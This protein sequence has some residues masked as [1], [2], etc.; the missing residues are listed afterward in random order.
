[1]N[2][3]RRHPRVR[4]LLTELRLWRDLRR[5]VTGSTV[6]APGAVPLPAV[7]GLWFLPGALTAATVIEIIAIELLIPWMSARIIVTVISVYSLALLWAILGQRKIYPHYVLAGDLVIRHGRQPVM[8][9]SSELILRATVA[10]TYRSERATVRD[11]VLVLGNGSGTSL[12]IVLAE[13][14]PV[15]DPDRWP[16]QKARIVRATEILLWVD[17]PAAA[18]SILTGQADR[19]RDA[20][21]CI[22]I[23]HSQRR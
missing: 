6:L 3:L 10:R 5:P 9:V 11:D 14:L 15:P 20:T 16:W 4:L 19:T 21:L 8:T 18:V 22:H 12:R 7:T 17:D 2:V 23:M 13:S 1:V